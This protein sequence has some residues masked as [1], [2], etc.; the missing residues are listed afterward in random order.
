VYS[1][2]EEGLSVEIVAVMDIF[3]FKCYIDKVQAS[4]C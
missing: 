2:S 1:G 4:K 3:K